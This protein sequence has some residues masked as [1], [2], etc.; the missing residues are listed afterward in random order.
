MTTAIKNYELWLEKV[1]D[2]ALKQELEAIRNNQNAIENAFYKDL[3]F[4]TGGLRGEI[5]VGTNCLNIYTIAKATQGV[6]D[7]MLRKNLK[8]VAI[9]YDSRNKSDEFSKVTA[10]VL[11]SNGIKAYISPTLAP[12]PHLSFMVRELKC[13]MGIMVTASHNPAKYNGYKVYDNNGC[14]VTDNQ[15]NEILSFIEKIDPFAIKMDTFESYLSKGL[16]SIID[17]SLEGE[18]IEKVMSYSLDT[19]DGLEVIYSPLNG[20]GY[21]IIPQLLTLHSVKLHLVAEQANPD[22]NFPTCPYPN[23]EKP[24]ALALGIEL[25]KETGADIL[26]A[27]DP[28]ADRMGVAV[29]HKGEILLLT[30]NEMGVLIANYIFTKRRELGI[31]PDNPVLVKTIVSTP[32]AHKIAN[33]HGASVVNVLTGF[34][35]IGEYIKTLEDLKQES[36]FIFGFEESYGYLAGTYVRDKDAVIAS[37]LASEMTAYYKKQGKTLIDKINEIYDE[38]GFYQ[39]QLLTYTFEGASGNT[40]MQELLKNLRANLPLEI[41]GVKVNKTIDYLTQTEFPLPKA[42]VISFDLADDS[43]LIIRPSGTEPLIKAYL[44]AAATIEENKKIFEK[45]KMFLSQIL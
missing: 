43:Q 10:C 16:I 27:T 45:L 37:M 28:D 21:R 36:R 42:D 31:L 39:H 6:A 11:A 18:Y 38:F 9:S 30:G 23:P 2:K 32:L 8:S 20:A 1:T 44:T 13:D 5:S 19:A 4:G 34:K 14:Q 3:I 35:Y 40:K 7:Y 41:S 29:N 12:T 17:D 24:E 25:L 15:A 26:I 22:G 33:K